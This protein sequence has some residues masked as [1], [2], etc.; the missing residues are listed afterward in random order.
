M[1]NTFYLILIIITGISGVFWIIKK[2]CIMVVSRNNLLKKKVQQLRNDFKYSNK[3]CIVLITGIIN[4]YE[5][6]SSMFPILL[7]VFTTRSFLYEPFQIPSG[8]M[9]PTLL[10]G[11]F[12][13]VNKFIYGIKNPINQKIL[14]SFHHPKRGDLIVFQYPKDPKFNY[15][16]RVIGEPRDKVVYNIIGK[17]L[18]IYPMQPDGTYSKE[19]SVVYSNIIPSNFVQ[20][21]YKS[22][23]GIIKSNFIKID[24]TE[25]IVDGIRLIKTTESLNKVTHDILTMISPG[26]NRFAQVQGKYSQQLI[27]EWLVPENEYF[28]MGDNRDNSSDSRYWGCV[29]ESNIIGKAVMIWMS[30][31]KDEGKWPTDIL[32]SRIGIIL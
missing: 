21:F 22:K 23:D 18:I 29:P 2:F 7:L 5:F 9:M 8:S 30:F 19:L 15:I 24:P 32:F 11:D 14:V 3:I 13:L 26:D 28:V 20:T 17:K 10:I 1:I 25:K 31:E 4:I 27:S 16:K 6:I 12:I